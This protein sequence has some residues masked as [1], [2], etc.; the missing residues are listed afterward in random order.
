MPNLNFNDMDRLTSE[1]NSF[2]RSNVPMPEGLKHLEK[3]MP[4]GKLKQLSGELAEATANGVPLSQA[5]R[6]ATVTV[7]PA[8][9]AMVRCGEIT[10]NMNEMLNF[11]MDN[12]RRIRRHRA[13]LTTL[14]VYPTIVLV[15][16]LLIVMFLLYWVVPQ[17]VMIYDQIGAELPAINQ[18]IIQASK[19]LG[20]NGVIILPL[21]ILAAVFVTFMALRDSLPG[22]LLNNVPGVGKLMHL[23][24]TATMTEALAHLLTRGVPLPDACRAASLTVSQPDMRKSLERMADT[25]E[26]GGATADALDPDVPATAAWLY[27]QG[28]ARGTLPEA[29]KGIS[30]YCEQRF[31]MV[32][33]RALHAIE[34]LFVVIISLFCGF[35]TVAFYLPLFNLPKI[36][37]A[38]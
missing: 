8:F 2:A 26:K 24:D 19:F 38:N 6:D 15:V 35:V 29:C 20:G 36:L 37:G 1:L 31:D 27:R 9:S 17:F 23:S 3:T 32:S 18:W 21:L 13:S 14:F 5:L 16:F 4:P 25:A 12:A 33:R 7:P 10:G 28:E 34:P 11:A 30:A 22:A